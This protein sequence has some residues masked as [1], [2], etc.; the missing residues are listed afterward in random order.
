MWQR[1]KKTE[2]YRYDDG[3]FHV[4]EIFDS[5]DGEGKRTGLMAIFVRLAGCNLRCSYCDTAYSLSLADTAEALTEEELLARI[6]AFP[7]KKI[8]LTGGE[9]MLHPIRH[10][11]EVLGKEGYEVNIETNGAVP[12][13]QERPQGTFYTMDF[14]C[15]GSG[16]KERMLEANFSFLGKEDVLKFVVSSQAD[17]NEMKEIIRAH[18]HK[19]EDP[20][21]YVSPVWGRIA[22]AD[23]VEYVRR[24]RLSDVRVQVQ[25]HKIIWDPERRGV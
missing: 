23:L 10:L 18:F 24:E 13:F 12:L 17:M 22:P 6:H 25:L 8:T 15:S 5:I 20:A 21:F 19:G 11:C 2:A 3:L 1:M 16:M 4:T 7:W 9:P 14:K